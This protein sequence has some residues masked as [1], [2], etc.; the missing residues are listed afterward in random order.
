M[1]PG[2]AASGFSRSTRS[3]YLPSG[4]K[5]MSWLSGFVATGRSKRAACRAHVA[6]RH[7]AER[8]AQIVELDLRGGEQEIA[9]VARRIDRGM[10][11]RPARCRD[12]ARVV[13]GRK[14]RRPQ[15]V[16]DRQ[17]VAELDRAVALDARD[18]RFAARIA[19]DEIGDHRVLEAALV[20]EHVMRDADP[21]GD[22]ARVVDVLARTA[23]PLLLR[24][25]PVVVELQR[26]ADHVVA[27]FLEQGRRHRRIHAARH[28]DDDA[29]TRRQVH[30]ETGGAHASS[31]ICQ[32][33]ASSRQAV[34]KVFARSS[35]RPS[36]AR[37]FHSRS[38]SSATP[39][40]TIAKSSP[41]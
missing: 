16:R 21:V 19:V 7:A 20:V 3:R 37:T 13:A 18:R 10:Q 39:R 32:K 34:S 29:C 2:T 36:L 41:P 11:L 24:R 5:Q 25:R 12:A 15:V 22:V 17:K 30:L 28:R 8:E 4:T 33:A 35:K 23:G 40:A 6:L 9:L 31:P 38:A 27:G 1:S 14:G 26:D